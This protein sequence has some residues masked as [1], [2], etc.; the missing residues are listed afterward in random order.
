[1]SLLLMRK[2]TSIAS[3]HWYVWGWVIRKKG[4]PNGCWCSKMLRVLSATSL[5]TKGKYG[6]K[7]T[8]NGCS[9]EAKWVSFYASGPVKSHFVQSPLR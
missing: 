2:P 1:M 6:Q 4:K 7:S 3:G 9:F 5:S 8:V